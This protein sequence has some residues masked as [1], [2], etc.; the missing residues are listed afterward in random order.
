MDEARRKC[1]LFFCERQ[2]ALRDG[3]ECGIT[4]GHLGSLLLLTF[5]P[6]ASFPPD[7]KDTWTCRTVSSGNRHADR[8]V[9][10]KPRGQKTEYMI[11]RTPLTSSK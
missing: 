4:C 2:E 10:P 1:Y 8:R 6:A 11:Q 7:I 5:F 3:R 9:E